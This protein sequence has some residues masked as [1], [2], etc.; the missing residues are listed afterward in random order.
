MSAG[1]E[2]SKIDDLRP[3]LGKSLTGRPHLMQYIPIISA[4]EDTFFGVRNFFKIRNCEKAW[5]SGK[6]CII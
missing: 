4:E 1:I 5:D 2:R 3:Y 6:L